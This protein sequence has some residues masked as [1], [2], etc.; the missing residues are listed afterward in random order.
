MAAFFRRS[1]LHPVSFAPAV[2]CLAAVV[3][4]PAVVRGQDTPTVMPI[5]Y[6][7][8]PEPTDPPDP[9]PR[10]TTSPS[11]TASAA[12]QPINIST[13]MQVGTGENVAIAGFIVTGS[14]AKR[15][16]VRALGPSLEQA[17]VSG[18]LADPALDF[19]GP[20]GELIVANDNWQD[21]ADAAGEISA[22]GLALPQDHEAGVVATMAPV[23]YTAV[24]TGH[25]GG[26]GNALVEVYDLQ[27]QAGSRI[28]NIS[29]R[30]LVQ[31]GDGVMIGGFILGKGTATT[32]VI[33]RGIGPS[34]AATG[35]TD[36]LADPTLE[37]HDSNGMLIGSN[38]NWRAQQQAEIEATGIPPTD[39]L[40]AA[41][42]MELPPG[43]YTAILA[44]KGDASGVGLVEVY[45][46]R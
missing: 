27:Q 34:L 8:T 37:L 23:S 3:F 26:S 31:G 17:G 38:D 45:D 29:T 5:I 10:P 20:N 33:A 44:G 4:L 46:L 2:C 41:L 12:T 15:V 43:A 36:P 24:L 32:K 35:V 40:E 11:P 21:D 42:V 13:R 25:D 14:G 18:A 6:Y 1:H 16:A 28:A 30:G 22:N 39:D 19:F 9:T 7:P